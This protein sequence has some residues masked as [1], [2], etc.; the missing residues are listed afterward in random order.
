M[1]LSISIR[2]IFFF[3]SLYIICSV[4]CSDPVV[5][6]GEGSNDMTPL[7]LPSSNTENVLDAGMSSDP[8]IP[9]MMNSTSTAVTFGPGMSVTCQPQTESC[10]AI[11]NDCDGQVDEELSCPC[12]QD[13]TCY[14]GPPTSR[15]IGLCRDGTRSCDERGEVWEMCMD[16]VGPTAENCQGGQDED[17]DGQ[18]DE[19]DC[20]DFCTPGESRACYTGPAGTENVGICTG[21]TQMCQSNQNW[22]TCEG[23]QLPVLEICD[24]GIDNDCDGIL[25]SDCYENLP[26]VVDEREVGVDVESRPVDFIMAIDNSGSMNDTVELVEEN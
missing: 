8:M 7:M 11:D 20:I 6:G 21:G 24:D 18:V 23:E 14:G 10:D 25:D 15:G 13:V 26:D 17:C 9:D 2:K 19:E 16:W 4:G 22:G 5:S 1:L 12:S 3:L